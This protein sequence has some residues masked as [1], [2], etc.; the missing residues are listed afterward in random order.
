MFETCKL[1]DKM[2][3]DIEDSYSIQN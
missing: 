2:G 3:R 1:K